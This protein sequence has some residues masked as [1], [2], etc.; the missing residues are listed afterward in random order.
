M[1]VLCPPWETITERHNTVQDLIKP[2]DLNQARVNKCLIALV[3]RKVVLKESSTVCDRHDFFKAS[4]RPHRSFIRALF[5]TTGRGYFDVSTRNTRRVTLSM[6][7]NVS[8]TGPI[9]IM[10]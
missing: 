6:Y 1:S 8:S 3:N 4:P 10:K 5:F 9:R 2:P 7:N